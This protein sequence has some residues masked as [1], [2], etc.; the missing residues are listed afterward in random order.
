MEYGLREPLQVVRA[1]L[2]HYD[3]ENV[4]QVQIIGNSEGRKETRE[5]IPGRREWLKLKCIIFIIDIYQ[6]FYINIYVTCC[7]S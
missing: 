7:N 3:T 6:L 2:V 5:K 4:H 1:K